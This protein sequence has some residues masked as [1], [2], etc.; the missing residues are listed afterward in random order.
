[1]RRTL[2]MVVVVAL[3]ASC[4]SGGGQRSSGPVVTKAGLGQP[5]RDEDFEF[6]VLGVQCG[7]S[8]IPGAF[9]ETASGQ[10]CVARV[11][12]K[13]VNGDPH[14]TLFDSSQYLFDQSGKRFS[15]NVR[16][17]LDANT[18]TVAFLQEIA[19][20]TTVEGVLV[21]DVPLGDRPTRMEL[22]STSIS[23]GVVVGVT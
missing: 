9:H 16:A 14:H 8:G 18:S 13:N 15:A 10:F 4:G 6:T 17:N 3:A 22:H 1:M 20:G 21:Y 11:R 19:T 12:V 5:V 2:F 23:R 7:V